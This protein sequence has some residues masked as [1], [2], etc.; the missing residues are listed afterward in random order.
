[1]QSCSSNES[2]NIGFCVESSGFYYNLGKGPT[3]NVSFTEGEGLQERE[4]FLKFLENSSC[5]LTVSANSCGNECCFCDLVSY[6]I[7]LK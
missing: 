4:E 2:S 1:M 6:G 5:P 7:A 3:W